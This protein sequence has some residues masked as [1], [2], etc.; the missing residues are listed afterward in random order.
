MKPWSTAQKRYVYKHIHDK[1]LPQIAKDIGRSERALNL[2]LHRNRHDP[3]LCVTHRNLLYQLL[4]K[5]F[6][7]VAC[8]TPT[9]TFFDAVQ[10]GQK[11]Y[12]SVFKGL[13]VITEDE[14]KRIANYLEVTLE[15]IYEVR[16][17]E[18]F[19]NHK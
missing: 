18:L 17:T 1:P 11:R 9:R 7:D 15:D 3:R 19:E 12:W 6:K 16:Q 5:K 8:F 14:L 13:E 4:K 10:M 2:F